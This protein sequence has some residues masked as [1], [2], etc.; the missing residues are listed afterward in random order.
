M[1]YRMVSSGRGIW[2]SVPPDHALIQGP[3]PGVH[4]GSPCL[5]KGGHGVVILI[6]I[7]V[8]NF[9]TESRGCAEAM[10]FSFWV[11]PPNKSAAER[12]NKLMFGLTAACAVTVDF[13]KCDDGLV[14]LARTASKH[15]SSSSPPSKSIYSAIFL[16]S[17]VYSARNAFLLQT[18]LTLTAIRAKNRR[19]TAAAQTF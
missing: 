7:L 18:T 9:F 8:T 10:Q 15:S 11:T 17:I 2:R 5:G 19:E 1:L 6:N 14:F 12:E 13:Q 3:N 4:S 16:L